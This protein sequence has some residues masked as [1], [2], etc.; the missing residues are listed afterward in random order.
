MRVFS[1]TQTLT[2]IAYITHLNVRVNLKLIIDLLRVY[3][4]W[5][6]YG[7]EEAYFSCTILKEDTVLDLFQNLHSVTTFAFE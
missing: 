2:D 3:K 6:K 1:I 7:E 5:V 4:L